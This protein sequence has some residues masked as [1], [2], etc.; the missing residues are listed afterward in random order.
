MHGALYEFFAPVS[1]LKL[2]KAFIKK[3]PD[4]YEEVA[5]RLSNKSHSALLEAGNVKELPRVRTQKQNTYTPD[6]ATSATPQSD[7]D[8]TTSTS[9]ST[10][11]HGPIDGYVGPMS[12]PRQARID[13]LLFKLFV[14]TRRKKLD[15]CRKV[16]HELVVRCRVCDIWLQLLCLIIH[17]KVVE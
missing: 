7:D 6:K 3:Y 16:R 8:P 1:I 9:I 13:L 4:L 2:T 14:C 15:K 17:E 10:T 5:A 12:K 11:P